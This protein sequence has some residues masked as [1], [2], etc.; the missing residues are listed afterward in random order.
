MTQEKGEGKAE[1]GK[2]ETKVEGKVDWWCAKCKKSN[3]AWRT[4]CFACH[5]PKGPLAPLPSISYTIDPSPP[6]I[7]PGPA[8][9]AYVDEEEANAIRSAWEAICG[10]WG[11]RDR[12]CS[13]GMTVS[14][15]KGIPPPPPP[16][17]LLN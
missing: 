17:Q 1:E 2:G 7:K 8:D 16:L 6:P 13:V 5:T 3:F 11:K 15:E 10:S 14:I 4:S 12:Y 9:L